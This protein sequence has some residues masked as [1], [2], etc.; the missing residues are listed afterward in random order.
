M[1]F[2]RVRGKL[3]P[4]KVNFQTILDIVFDILGKGTVND[5]TG[6]VCIR[7]LLKTISQLRRRRYR[8]RYI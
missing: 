6:G 5:F 8:V 1:L 3:I 7:C 4:S 2:G